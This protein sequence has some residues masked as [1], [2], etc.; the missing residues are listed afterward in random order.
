M[1]N[2]DLV[3]LL[4]LSE[5]RQELCSELLIVYLCFILFKLLVV[6]NLASLM[7][8]SSEVHHGLKRFFLFSFFYFVFRFFYRSSSAFTSPV[9]H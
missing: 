5:L 2:F 9:F 3:V 1:G 6:E 7:T 4:H 8:E